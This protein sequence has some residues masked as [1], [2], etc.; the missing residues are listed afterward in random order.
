MTLRSLGAIELTLDEDRQFTGALGLHP[1]GTLR[2]GLVTL[3]V[4]A[5][6]RWCVHDRGVVQLNVPPVVGR[7]GRTIGIAA[8]QVVPVINRP[9]APLTQWSRVC[10]LGGHGEW[11]I[12]LPGGVMM[13][14]TPTTPLRPDRDAV[15]VV[16]VLSLRRPP[17]R[18]AF[19]IPHSGP[20]VATVGLGSDP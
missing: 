9:P 5:S 6:D 18:P 20:V 8:I 3:V 7:P 2:S 17:E 4:D 10:Y 1:D 13:F 16:E 15:V 19:E 14:V 11:W 12:V